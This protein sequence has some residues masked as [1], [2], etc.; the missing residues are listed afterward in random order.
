MIKCQFVFQT[1]TFQEEANRLMRW[2]NDLDSQ[3]S[4]AQPVGGLPE[5][6]REQLDKHKVH[7]SLRNE[8]NVYGYIYCQQRDTGG[9]SLVLH[10]F[11]W[12]IYIFG[13]FK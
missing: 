3:L 7:T 5:T 13:C 11:R 8:Y 9:N 4:A 1:N 6:A 12:K 10:L 2:L